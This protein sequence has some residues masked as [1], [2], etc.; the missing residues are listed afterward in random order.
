MLVVTGASGFIGSN[1][2]LRLAGAGREVVACDHYA[3]E[4]IRHRYLDAARIK[5]FVDK[6]DL[7]IWLAQNE[8]SVK[9]V[10]HLGACSDTMV[11]DRAFVMRVN[12]EYTRAIW[13]FC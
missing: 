6:D 10:I 5:A 4:N 1:V 12:Y 9:A 11:T 7:H 13:N 8:S 2:A 3:P